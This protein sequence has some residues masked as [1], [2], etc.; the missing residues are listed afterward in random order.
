[1]LLFE[2]ITWISKHGFYI[3]C[4]NNK[5][6]FKNHLKHAYFMVYLNGILFLKI[7]KK[8]LKVCMGCLKMM[9]LFSQAC[10]AKN[11]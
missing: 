8:I 2:T 4:V 11:A 10:L 5:Y 1:M 9:K 6:D 3:T 7:I